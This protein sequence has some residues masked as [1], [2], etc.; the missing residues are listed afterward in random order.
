MCLKQEQMVTKLGLE[1]LA[2]VVIAVAAVEEL[3]VIKPTTATLLI[4][5]LLEVIKEF[6]SLKL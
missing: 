5:S 4:T 2:E 6:V 3:V 1:Q